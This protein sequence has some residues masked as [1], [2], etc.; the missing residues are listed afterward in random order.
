MTFDRSGKL[1]MVI[2]VSGA[3]GTGKSTLCVRLRQVMPELGFSI[4]C[5]TRPP[6]PREENGV[7]YYYLERDEF[8]R[9]LAAGEFLEYAQVFGNYYGTLKSEVIAR[10]EAGTDVLLDIDVQGAL[11]IRQ[12]ALDDPVLKK[13]AEFIFVAPPSLAELEARLRE[14]ST[15]SEEQIQ[16][17]LAEAGHEIS[18]WRHY[19]YLIV[20]AEFERAAGEMENLI[21]ALRLNTKRMPEEMIARFF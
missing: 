12:A 4:S 18:Y 20:N 17:R 2:V 19:D 3:S 14:R 8:K 1:G 10:V 15:D 9:R 5:T 11:Q 7:D 13:C 16:R 6:R 21:R